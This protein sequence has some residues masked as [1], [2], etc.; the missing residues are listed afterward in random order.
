MS[1]EHNFGN[2]FQTSIKQLFQFFCNNLNIGQWELAKSCLDQLMLNNDNFNFDI[3]QLL[4]DI[5]VNPTLYW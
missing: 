3:N 5:I 4:I 1:L 2:E